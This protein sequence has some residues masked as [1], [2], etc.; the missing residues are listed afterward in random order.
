MVIFLSLVDEYQQ[1][2]CLDRVLKSLIQS[3]TEELLTIL[4]QLIHDIR[5]N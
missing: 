2:G 1:R 4:S 5:Y 3:E